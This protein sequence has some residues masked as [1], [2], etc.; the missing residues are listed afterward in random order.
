MLKLPKPPNNFGIQSVNN[1]YKNCSLKER[2]LFLK[3]ES[4][5]VFKI[6]KTFDEGKAPGID[7]LSGIF[8]KD[9]ASLLATPITQLCN[10]SISSGRFPDSCKIAKLKPL[11]KKGSKTDPKNSLLP[12]ILK[13]LER[14]VHEQSM[15]FLD[16]H[17]ILYKFQSGF[18]KIDSTNYCLSYLTDRISKDFDSGPPTGGILIG[19]Q[20]V[21]DTINHNIL[22][23]KG[24]WLV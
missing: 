21:F 22:F 17:N 4:D 9:G 16:K 14:I 12:L 13:V 6:L 11:F 7:D 20:K 23:I 10:L 24:Y 5:K 18:R 8:L 1:Y 3:V 19:L 15:E 2:L